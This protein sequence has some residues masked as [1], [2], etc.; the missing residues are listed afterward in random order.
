MIITKVE[1]FVRHAERL[2][3]ELGHAII[4]IHWISLILSQGIRDCVPI[5]VNRRTHL[6]LAKY[7]LPSSLSIGLS[8][9]YDRG[10]KPKGLSRIIL[11]DGDDQLR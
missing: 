1:Q 6:K 2:V 8:G 11:H 4:R 5:S 9:F 10:K 3:D 7:I